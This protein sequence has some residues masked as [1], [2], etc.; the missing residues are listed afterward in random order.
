MNGGY[1]EKIASFYGN[2]DMKVLNY[3]AN[4]EFNDRVMMDEL[5]TRYRLKKELIVEDVKKEL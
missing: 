3:G 1:G 4:K 5:V 2:S